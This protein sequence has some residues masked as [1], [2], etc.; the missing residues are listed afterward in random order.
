MSC[1]HATRMGAFAGNN[2]AAELLGAPTTPYHQEASQ[3]SQRGFVRL[4]VRLL[5]A[6]PR[7]GGMPEHARIMSGLT[8]AMADSAIL[9]WNEKERY[10]FWRPVSAIRSGADGFAPLPAWLPLVETPPFPEYPSG[11][12]ADCFVGAGYLEA[13]F[14]DLRESIRY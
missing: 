9:V 2:A 13:A 10:A 5:A 6:H 11:H 1:Q 3:S 7:P 12:A 4:A 8:A 14:P